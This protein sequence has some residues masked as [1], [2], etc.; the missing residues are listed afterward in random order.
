MVAPAEKSFCVFE[1][2]TGKS[3]ATVQRAFR[4]KYAKDLPADKTVGVCYK[5]FTESGCLCKQKS[6]VR[7]LTAE[8]LE[9]RVDVCRFTSGAHIVHL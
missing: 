6:G 4:A 8:E 7:S 3:V 9:Y 2:H 1:Y 5:Q